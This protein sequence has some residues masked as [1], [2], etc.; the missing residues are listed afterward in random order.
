[1]SFNLISTS[2][3]PPSCI[4]SKQ[5]KLA[6]FLPSMRS[7]IIIIIRRRR[8]RSFLSSREFL[9]RRVG[10]YPWWWWHHSASNNNNNNKARNKEEEYSR[11]LCREFEFVGLVMSPFSR[12]S[13]VQVEVYCLPFEDVSSCLWKLSCFKHL[14]L[15]NVTCCNVAPSLI[16]PNPR[17]E[18]MCLI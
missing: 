15:R 1:M 16:S 13:L 6:C 7:I 10:F 9:N 18:R 11:A 2:D 4:T 5:P 3:P 8:R 14:D 17:R 12:V